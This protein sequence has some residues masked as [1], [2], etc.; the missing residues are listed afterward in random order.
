M[1]RIAFLSLLLLACDS[2]PPGSS[3]PNTCQS[4][5]LDCG[6]ADNG[7]G[8]EIDCGGC[9]AGESCGGSG[10]NR[11]GIAIC[12]PNSC[13]SLGYECGAA[14]DG[15]AALLDCGTCATGFC[16]GAGAH[17]CGA[18]QPA[19]CASLG[20]NC[21]TLDDGCGNPLDC[22][23]TCPA[24][25]TCGGGGVTNVC[26][27]GCVPNSCGMKDCG[28]IDDGCGHMVS[29]GMCSGYLTCGGGGTANVCGASCAS[30]C[31]DGFSCDNMGVCDGGNVGSVMLNEVGY[32]VSGAV[33]VGGAAP[34]KSATYCTTS[35]NLNDNLV[36]V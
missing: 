32:T 35:G 14:S 26:G 13:A 6:Q 16:G 29:C 31:P 28:M 17:R 30:G 25:Q 27:N 21:G 8:G 12:T 24:G 10:P 15:C 5:G 7:C 22:G 20:K 19:T 36:N 34:T 1:L 11:C 33:T 18:C 2:T 23:A 3:C 4:L 9:A